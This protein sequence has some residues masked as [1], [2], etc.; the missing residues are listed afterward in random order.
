MRNSEGAGTD[1]GVKWLNGERIL[2]GS[3][4]ERDK[5]IPFSFA[6]I[7]GDVRRG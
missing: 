1:G 4:R 5:E 2:R 3:S 6:G 7:A